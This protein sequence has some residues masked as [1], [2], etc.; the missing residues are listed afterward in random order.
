MMLAR[1][2][3]NRQRFHHFSSC[4]ERF[5]FARQ[6][7]VLGVDVV[8]DRHQPAVGLV[9]FGAHRVHRRLALDDLVHAVEIAHVPV[10]GH[11][12]LLLHGEVDAENA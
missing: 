4:A 9:E 2:H 10:A 12:A 11:R 3:S 1:E 7:V 5:D 8:I 6:L